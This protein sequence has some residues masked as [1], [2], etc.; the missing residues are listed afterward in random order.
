MS[1]ELFLLFSD[2]FK[3]EIERFKQLGQLN[4]SGSTLALKHTDAATL[5]QFIDSYINEVRIL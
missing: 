2:K 5:H 4:H 3:T 1:K